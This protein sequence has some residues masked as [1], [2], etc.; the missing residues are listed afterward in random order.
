VLTREDAVEMLAVVEGGD[1]KEV[2]EDLASAFKITQDEV[3][4]RLE[5]YMAEEDV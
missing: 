4:A 2:Y 3:D 5:E 1:A